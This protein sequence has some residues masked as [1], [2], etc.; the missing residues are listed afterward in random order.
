MTFLVAQWETAGNGL[1]RVIHEQ[2]GKLVAECGAAH[3]QPAVF[4]HKARVRAKKIRAALRLARP[5]MGGKAYARENRWWR[6]AARELS[7]LRDTSARIESLEALTPF[8]AARI[9]SA[10]TR[11]LTE[12]FAAE[13]KQTDAAQAIE[14]FRVRMAERAGSLT[15][16]MAA[17]GREEMAAALTATYREARQAM[18]AALKRGDPLLLHEWRKQ[19][20]YHALQARLMRMTFPETLEDRTSAAR[21]LSDVLGDIQDIEV[22]LENSQGWT[23]APE[24]FADALRD[25]RKALVADASHAGRKLFSDK[26][27][28]FR[29]RLLDPPAERILD[30]ERAQAEF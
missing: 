25:H 30:R 9:G 20:K 2:A 29:A 16:R 27:K 18:K 23:E 22:V 13:M 14:A 12:R 15:P 5:M 7:A 4:A 6:D 1:A 19:T 17:G 11:R 28:V 8:L 26:P 21:K 3:E 10:M 24:G